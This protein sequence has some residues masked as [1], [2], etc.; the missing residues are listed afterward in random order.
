MAAYGFRGRVTAAVAFNQAKWLDYY[1]ALI[2]TAAP[3]PPDF[4][5]MDRA[6]PFE[7][8]CRPSCRTRPF[9]A[10]A[11]PSRSPAICPPNVASSL[12]LATDS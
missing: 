4:D 2:E 1:R 3:F 7:V 11:P 12:R 9:S 8:A 6:E 5:V 10:T